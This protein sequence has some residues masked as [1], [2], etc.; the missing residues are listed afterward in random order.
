M[1]RPYP[2]RRNDALQ[3]SMAQKGRGANFLGQETAQFLATEDSDCDEEDVK[4]WK[5][6]R[7]EVVRNQYAKHQRGEQASHQQPCAQHITSIRRIAARAPHN[8]SAP[9]GARPHR[10]RAST[11]ASPR[12]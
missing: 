10:N 12:F 5:P 3:S 6:R 7:K 11:W 1:D 8:P 9:G 4:N 2:I